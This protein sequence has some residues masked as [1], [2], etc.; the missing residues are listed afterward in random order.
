[1][2]VAS[3]SPDQPAFKFINPPSGPTEDDANSNDV[4]LVED[5][6]SLGDQDRD[7]IMGMSEDEAIQDNDEPESESDS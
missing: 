1:M 7:S 6:G 5:S 3:H 4:V 2:Y